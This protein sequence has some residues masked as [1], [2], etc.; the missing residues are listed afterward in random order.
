M[1]ITHYSSNT[2]GKVAILSV[3]VDDIVMTGD[4]E[5]EITRMK[6]QL[7]KSFEVKDLGKLGYFLGIEVAYSSQGI[8]LSQR[9]YVLDLLSKTGMLHYKPLSTPIEQNHRLQ[10]EAGEQVDKGLYQRLVGHLIYLSHTRPD[11]AYAASIAS[12]YIH[13]PRK[14]HMDLVYRILQY[15]MG[16]PGKD[17]LFNI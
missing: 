17:I 1:F 10:A 16:C 12:R 9:K 4:D 15:L 2:R 11:I 14:G 13:D 6:G 5:V 3:Y 7:A 8:Y